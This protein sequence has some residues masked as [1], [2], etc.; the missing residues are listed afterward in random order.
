[1]DVAREKAH[2]TAHQSEAETEEM[3]RNKVFSLARFV[4]LLSERIY[5]LSPFTRNYLV[6]WITVLDSVPDL[7][8]VHY[9]PAFLDGLLKYLSDPNTDV[10]VATHNVLADFLRECKAA[11]RAQ[12]KAKTAAAVKQ[13]ITSKSTV[14]DADAN[15][16][17]EERVF[18]AAEEAEKEEGILNGGVGKIDDE[19]EPEE[20][21][22]E[23]EEDAWLPAQEVKI[24]YSAIMEILVSHIS[25]PGKSQFERAL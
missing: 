13:R 3:A 14:V 15:L 18:Q 5:V 1:M 21:E 9:L 11:A 17:E 22:Q 4:P 16:T 23:D 24:D 7:E 20:L 6:S 12:A 2:A 8:L 19:V 25:Y 10:R